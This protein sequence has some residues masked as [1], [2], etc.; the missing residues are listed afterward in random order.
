MLPAA[1]TAQVGMIEVDIDAQPLDQALNSFSAASGFQVFVEADLLVGHRSTAV[2]GL[3]ER[4]NALQQLLQGTDL[5]AH[6]IAAN[7]ITIVATHAA[8]AEVRQAKRAAAASYGAIQDTIVRALCRN[9]EAEPGQY[10]ASFQYWFDMFGRVTDFRMIRSS[11]DGRRDDAIGR[12]VRSAA[13]HFSARNVPQ[14]VTISIEPSG[15]E[16]ETG[17]LPGQQ[18]PSARVQ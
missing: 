12:A 5:V 14:P 18:V 11:G 17:C 13:I 15:R 1:A 4:E 8:T 6:L 2:K 9:A 3:I 10:R 16:G 7:T